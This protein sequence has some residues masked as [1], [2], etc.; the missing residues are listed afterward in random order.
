MEETRR[1][2]CEAGGTE[3]PPAQPSDMLPNLGALQFPTI[4]CA[5]VVYGGSTAWMQLMRSLATAIHHLSIPSLSP[6]VGVGNLK[7]K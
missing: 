7:S 4:P 2:R 3:L 5:G 1:A 6:G